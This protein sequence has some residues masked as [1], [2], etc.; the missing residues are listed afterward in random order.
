MCVPFRWT[1]N[2]LHAIG[3]PFWGQADSAFGNIAASRGSCG[4]RVCS[5]M[6]LTIPLATASGRSVYG[7]LAPAQ[8]RFDSRRQK[9]AKRSRSVP[10][11]PRDVTRA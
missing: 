5:S 8:K 4:V 6:L 3:M 2:A 11:C 1:G 9:Q 10:P 7:S